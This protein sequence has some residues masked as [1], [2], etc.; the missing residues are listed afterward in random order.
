MTQKKSS[1]LDDEGNIKMVDVGTKAVTQRIARAYAH[2]NANPDTVEAIWSGTL[3][4]GDALTTA[5]IAGIQAAKQTPQLIPMCHHLLLDLVDI[6]FEKT[7]K[8]IGLQSE[9]RLTGKTGA[10]MEALTAVTIAALTL[11]DMAKSVQKD[12]V[13]CDAYVTHKAGGKS[14][15]YEKK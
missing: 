1:H 8:G 4:K 6:T 11:Y 14:G 7:A 13:L 2:L 9:V 10:E 5:K 15:S 3:P 12:M